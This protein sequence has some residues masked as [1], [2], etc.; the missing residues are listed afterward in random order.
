MRISMPNDWIQPAGSQCEVLV[1]C[2]LSFF[3]IAV[4][5][6][7]SIITLLR[8]EEIDAEK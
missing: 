1:S 2:P 8:D 4:S 3:L 6:G 7:V 5:M